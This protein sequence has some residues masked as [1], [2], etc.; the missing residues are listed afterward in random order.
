MQTFLCQTRLCISALYTKD[1]PSQW[2][3]IPSVRVK[4]ASVLELL[5]VSIFCLFSYIYI[6]ISLRLYNTW[7]SRSSPFFADSFVSSRTCSWCKAQFCSGASHWSLNV[8]STSQNQT[9]KVFVWLE[10]TITSES[11]PSQGV[12]L[13]IEAWHVN[14]VEDSRPLVMDNHSR[15]NLRYVKAY[16][17]WD[18]MPSI[19][20]KVKVLFYPE[21]LFQPL[22]NLFQSPKPTQN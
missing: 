12:R 15:I 21:I 19:G 13:A 3:S 17:T 1:L 5:E 16:D 11:F 22:E 14:F 2:Y 10:S 9:L 4:D 6:Y 7:S 8:D 18:M 20:Q